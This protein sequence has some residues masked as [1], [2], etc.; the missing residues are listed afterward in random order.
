MGTGTSCTI[1]ADGVRVADGAPADDPT[2]PTALSGLSI[3]WGRESTVDQPDAS[4]CSVDL[5]DSPG[6]PSFGETFRTGTAL[7]VT[8]TGTTYPDPTVSTFPDPGFEASDP[9]TTSSVYATVTAST[10]RAHGGTRSARIHP[11]PPALTPGARWSTILAPAEFADPGDPGAWDEIPATSDGQRWSYGGWFYVPVGVS[12]TIAPVLFTGPWAGSAVAVPGVAL[13]YPGAGAWHRLAGLFAP[14]LAGAWVGLAISAYPTGATWDSAVGTW[15]G[16]DPT[17]TWDDLGDV[18]LDDVEVLAPAGGVA[19][20]VL[21]YAGRVTS[22]T[23]AYDE[24]A[25]A[26]LIRVS[27]V[28]FTADLDNRDVGDTP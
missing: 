21:V 22:L 27:A 16:L 26:P 14:A 15:D 20:T 6:G 24:A 3:H 11:H 10:R 28:D 25:A 1:Y 7:T 4:T 13:T 8:A 9:V 18:Y 5:I 12:V 23:S 17:L 19:S 2:A